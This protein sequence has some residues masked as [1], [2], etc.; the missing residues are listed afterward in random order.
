M[1]QP[2]KLHISH[3]GKKLRFLR[4]ERELTL[5]ALAKLA[6][7][8]K[9]YLWELENK[10]SKRPSAEKLISL[11]DALNVSHTYFIGDEDRPP[12][13]RELDEAFYRKYQAMWR[14]DKARLRKIA[15]IFI[16]E[17]EL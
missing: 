2:H 13:A 8:S 14:E 5:D 12:S 3:L 9:S 7:T 11:A 6:G 10:V 16:E 15:E 1:T 17:R 4:K